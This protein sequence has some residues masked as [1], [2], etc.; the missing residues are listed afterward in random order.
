ML[1]EFS[2]PTGK[3]TAQLQM[4]LDLNIIPTHIFVFI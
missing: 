4:V 2:E 3:W 1:S